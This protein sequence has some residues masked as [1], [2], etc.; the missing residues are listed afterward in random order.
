E[1][2]LA[3]RLVVEHDRGGPRA[4]DQPRVVDDRVQQLLVQRVGAQHSGGDG[5]AKAI[6][7]PSLPTLSAAARSSD[8]SSKGTR[9]GCLARASAA[10]P[11]MCG[12]AKLLPVAWI[13]ECSSH[14]SSTLTPRARNS[15]GGA[16]G[17]HCR[18]RPPPAGARPRNTRRD[19]P[20]RR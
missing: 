11:A 1:H 13:V 19:P 8:L 20:P 6:G 15:T 9:P 7:H 16:G 17:D 2:E 18:P 4:E 14:A 10:S 12:V 5:L 3:R